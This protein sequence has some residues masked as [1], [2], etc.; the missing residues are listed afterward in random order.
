[1]RVIPQSGGST[2]SRERANVICT[3]PRTCPALGPVLKTAPNVLTSKKFWQ[4]HQRA[5]IT[6]FL[7]GV[8]FLALLSHVGIPPVCSCALA[9]FVLRLVAC[10]IKIAFGIAF[11]LAICT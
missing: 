6:F 9:I 3:G 2:G 10:S 5:S 8:H 11:P 1:M 7:F 4:S